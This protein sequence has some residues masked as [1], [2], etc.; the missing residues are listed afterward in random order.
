LG[1]GTNARGSLKNGQ[2]RG[3]ITPRC[4]SKI[5]PLIMAA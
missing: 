4:Y 2:R 5:E 1:E 3:G